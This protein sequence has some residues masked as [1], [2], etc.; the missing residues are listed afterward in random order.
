MEPG[1]KRGELC[2]RAP[3][4][5]RVP[6]VEHGIAGGMR[7]ELHQ[8]LRPSLLARLIDWYDRSLVVVFR[9]Q[10]LTLLVAVGTV[11]LTVV[12]YVVIPK[13]FFP[14]QDN[15]LIQAITEAPQSISFQAM[16]ERQRAR[17]PAGSG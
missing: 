5:V 13:G 17:I 2:N 14:V 16:S 15:G 4:R 3:V 11:V 10:P 12:L 8:Q 1:E 7:A 6:A 9:H